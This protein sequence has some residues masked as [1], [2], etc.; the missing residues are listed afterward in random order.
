MW[1]RNLVDAVV[2]LTSRLE[3]GMAGHCIEG[4]VDVCT[5]LEVHLGWQLVGLK[6]TSVFRYEISIFWRLSLGKRQ[7]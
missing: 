6:S 4:T 7:Q 3:K 1:H 2:E 5:V